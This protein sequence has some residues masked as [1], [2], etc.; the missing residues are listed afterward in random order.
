MISKKSKIYVAGHNGLVGSSIVRVL[1]KNGY[2][3][4]LYTN[5]KKLDL[6]DQK[7]VFKYLKKNKPKFI[8]IAA[9]KVGGILSNQK[10]KADFIYSNLSIQTNLINSAFL[11]GINNLIF[12]DQVVFIKKL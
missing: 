4:I 12:W 3:N 8:F 1:K 10:Y 2:K 5:K 11:C 9:A 6:T 7:K